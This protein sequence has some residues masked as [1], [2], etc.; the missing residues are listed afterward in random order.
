MTARR[1]AGLRNVGK[2]ALADFDRLGIATVAQLAGQ[3]ADDLYVRLCV[4]SGAR[5]DPC[6]HDVF[7]AAIH[8]AKTGEARKWWDFTGARKDRQSAGTFPKV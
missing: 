3:S 4:E 8:E 7:A 6:V 5:Q 1:L 2:A